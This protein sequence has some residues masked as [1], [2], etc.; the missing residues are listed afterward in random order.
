MSA[1]VN[2]TAPFHA[3]IVAAGTGQR[4]GGG[5]P[6]QYRLLAGKPVL[7]RTV[8]AF[9]GTP[10]LQS[11]T[12]VIGAGQEADCASALSGIETLTVVPGGASRQESVRNGLEDLTRR[13]GD[14]A[15]AAVVL[16][17]D[18]ARPFA[19]PRMIQSVSETAHRAGAALPAL[20]VVDT[21]KSA[22]ADGTVAATVPRAGLHRAQTPQGFR[23]GAILAAHRAADPAQEATDDAMLAELAGLPITLVPGEETNVK[24]TTEADFAAAEQRLSVARETRTGMGFDVH[25]LVTGDH[26]WL[27]G[28]RIDHDQTLLGHSDADVGLHAITDAILG[29][30]GDGDIGQHFPP[31]D[32]QWKG[33]PSDAFLRH[34]ATL[35]ARRDA[36]IL[37]VDATLI[38]EAPKVGPHR[39]AMRARVADILGLSKDRVSIKATTTEKLGFTGR[40]EGIACQAV[41]TL[42]LPPYEDESE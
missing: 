21:L 7:R 3:L 34:A 20:P 28:I 24:L 22:A 10:G 37:H 2:F 42:S 40:G 9:A 27:C 14:A 8:D 36:K 33:A 17:H 5:V 39:A 13:L 11:I 30:L 38:C 26:L 16:I 18:A 31:S 25:R 15:E 32:P 1:P 12:V 19:T 4:A 23:L 29:A 35:A 41:A 6:K